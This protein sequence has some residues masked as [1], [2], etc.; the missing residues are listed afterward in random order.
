M[1]KKKAKR[2]PQELRARRQSLI[3][4]R[5]QVIGDM[6]GLMDTSEDYQILSKRLDDLN[7]EIEQL[8]ARA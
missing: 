6:W 2:N 4:E 8:E 1:G 5:T 3:I 7:A